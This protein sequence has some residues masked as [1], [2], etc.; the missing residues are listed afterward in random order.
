MMRDA[1][2]V[3]FSASVPALAAPAFVAG[4]FGDRVLT[5]FQVAQRLFAV[6]DLVIQDKDALAG[7][8]VRA[9]AVDYRLQPVALLPASGPAP[10]PLLATR[11]CPGDRLAAVVA[12]ADLELLLRRHPPPAAWSVEVT[13]CPLPMR[14]WLAALVRTV[15]GCPQ[16]DAEHAVGC[17]PLRLGTAL[18]RGQGEDLLAQLVRER[19]AARLVAADGAS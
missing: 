5:I 19:V 13:E 18:T 8:S 10:R 15:R 12:L 9:A 7:Q 1:A 6:I 11:L 16:A 14:G 3:E 17:L 2:H 4:L